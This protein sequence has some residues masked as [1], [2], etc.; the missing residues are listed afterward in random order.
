M[1]FFQV[2]GMNKIMHKPWNRVLFSSKPHAFIFVSA[3][4]FLLSSCFNRV[5]MYGLARRAPEGE[6]EMVEFSLLSA[7]STSNTGVKVHFSRS[8]EPI[9]AETESNYLIPGLKVIS[10]LRDPSD[11]ALV[12]LSTYPQ[13]DVNYTLTVTG[14]RDES[15]TLIG[16]QNSAVFKGDSAP[17]IKSVSSF[18]NTTVVIFFS[19]AVDQFTAENPSNYNIPG[20]AVLSAVRDTI[21]PAKVIL[22]TDSQEDGVSYTITINNVCD[23]TGNLL[24]GIRFKSFIGTGPIDLTPP[25]VLLA[26]LADSNT[27]LVQFSEPIEQNSAEN[28]G[29]YSIIDKFSNPVMIVSAL[30]QLDPS[31]VLLSIGGMFSESLYYLTVSTSV[32]DLNGNPL[33]GPPDNTVSFNG[34]GTYIASV[35]ATSNTGV[36]VI[37]SS[38]VELSG[39]ENLSNYTIPGLSVINAKRD[40]T[41]Y[42]IVDLT[43]SSQEDITYTL[44]VKGVIEEDSKSFE[45]DI[46]PY[47]HS[48]SSFG[49]TKVVIYFSETMEKILAEIASNYSITG[50]S[51]LSATRDESNPARV[52]LETSSQ[53]SDVNYSLTISNLT[54]LT[55][56]PLAP[57]TTVNFT[58]TGTVDTLEPRV[59]SA[60]LIDSDTVEVRFSEPMDELSSEDISNYVLRDND[61]INVTILSATRQALDPSKVWIDASSSFSKSLYI[62]T[63]STSV[64]DVNGN[65]LVGSPNNSASFAGEAPIP[66]S[67]NEGAVIVDP[68]NEGPN[69]FSLLAKYRGRIY[70]GPTNASNAIFRF[71]PDGTAPELVTFTF[72]VG[73]IYK[74]TLDTGPDGEDGI[75][76]IAGGI[77]DGEE[78]LFIGPSKSGGDL[79]YIYFTSESG[80]TL[81]FNPVNLNAVLGG[82]TKGVSAMIVFNS[83]LY[84]GY[85]DTGG[86]RPYLHRVVNIAENPAP[87][88]EV[89]NL[90]GDSM[91][92]IGAKGTPKNT[93]GIVGID[94][95]SIF[96]DHL[97]LANGGHNAVNEDGGILRST[98]NNPLPYDSNPADWEDITDTSNI[99]WYNSPL[100]N[101]FST[102]LPSP[103]KL[104]P[105]DRAFPAMAVFNG[106]LYVIRNTVG[107][108]AG[109][110]LWKYDGFSWSLVADNGG[111]LTDMGNI[112]NS[113]A[114][115]LVANGDR[116]YIGYDNSNDGVEVWRTKSGVTEPF[117]A[118][119]FEQVATSGLGDQ[120]NNQRI[121]HGLS[122]NDRGE[123]YLWI[124]CGKSGGTVRVYRTKNQ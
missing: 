80:S 113:S 22:T 92:R 86:N 49:N 100:L 105:A 116:L 14:V 40:V 57:P 108:P 61:N 34:L 76:Y 46:A 75:D 68:M 17:F 96:N 124:L 11:P 111:G 95:F 24:T 72:H 98:T 26:N 6:A 110:Q 107:S 2:S 112:K 78:Y 41:D 47:I 5:D 66:Q 20:L 9:S 73:T 69:N 35:K 81:N 59:L 25:K 45:G 44:T 37:F 39:A 74:D 55:A 62:L 123:N 31:Q 93:A 53:V 91:S 23:I 118:S 103:N 104:I 117:F 84:I 77:I 71:K 60:S 16:L 33:V 52:N 87:G 82:Q 101:R 109:P 50:L 83:N 42:S 115:L 8:V 43:T 3:M 106:K 36:R 13:E 119:D 19:E 29:N 121:Y 7:E 27:V 64:K 30:C 88:I 99:K 120:A 122:I 51:V 18:S 65:P 12:N 97:Y 63:V 89:L 15:F 28:I 10:A 102:E 85:P 21:D 56:N 79:N 90:N 114:T 70:I 94:S 1:N 32:V 58:G 67:F 4:L 38:D 54:D 48:V